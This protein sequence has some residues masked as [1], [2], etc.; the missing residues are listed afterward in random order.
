[1]HQRAGGELHGELRGPFDRGRGGPGG[2]VLTVTDGW[3]LV[4]AVSGDDVVR[5]E[6]F[7]A[8]ELDLATLWRW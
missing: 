7:D 5:A 8:V 4:L 3:L 6:P 2:W 1:M